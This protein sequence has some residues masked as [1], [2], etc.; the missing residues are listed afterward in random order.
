MREA[1]KLLE[2]KR[3]LLAHRQEGNVEYQV[4][5]IRTRAPIGAVRWT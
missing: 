1:A 3:K 2:R 4:S 5:L